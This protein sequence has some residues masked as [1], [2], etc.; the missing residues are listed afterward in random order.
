MLLVTEQ[1]KQITLLFLSADFN[2]A[3]S[4]TLLIHSLKQFIKYK[5]ILYHSMNQSEK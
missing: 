5:Y 3:A 4:Q 1:K 2:P